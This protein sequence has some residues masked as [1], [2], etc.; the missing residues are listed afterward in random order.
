M[1]EKIDVEDKKM[2]KEFT[3]YQKSTKGRSQLRS[4]TNYK[5]KMN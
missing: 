1:K 5:K 3:D 2:L 4:G